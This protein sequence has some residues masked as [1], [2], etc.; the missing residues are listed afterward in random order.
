M[1]IWLVTL[2]DDRLT[3]LSMMWQRGL[4]LWYDRMDEAWDESGW[5]DELTRWRGNTATLLGFESGDCVVPK[6]S[7]GHALRTVLNAF[8]QDRPVKVVATR[9]EF[10]SI[11][12]VLKIYTNLDRVEV[13]WTE[14]SLEEE[15]VPQFRVED[16]IAKL[17]P[18]TDL[19][20]VSAVFF[21]T[22]Q[23]LAGLDQLVEAAHSV[24]AKVLVDV[25]HAA[26]VI[27]LFLQQTGV[28]FAIGGSY[29]Y[30]RG[31]PGACWLAVHPA[32]LSE[33][34]MRSLD[35]GW[36]AKRNKF[37]YERTDEPEF[38]T[39]GDGWMESTPAVLLPYQARAGLQ[40]LLDLGVE[41]V[42][43]HSMQANQMLREVLG[44]AAFNPATPEGWG[45][46]SLV[47]SDRA[48]EL[49]AEL[50]TKGIK[51]DAR[52]NFVRICPD[53]LTTNDDIEQV[54]HALKV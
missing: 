36:F 13:V 24:G 3:K 22:G 34:E 15:G 50:K 21:T 51:V 20:V 29:K 44:S 31:G 25:Y 27:P 32:V 37:S 7:A 28:D 53:L 12:F 17:E 8:P 33:N 46:F 4:N 38:E 49:T 10:D 40:L 18:G 54:A 41:R 26:G 47:R 5:L 30:L 19:V 35:T 39:G 9:G 48:N 14:P 23:I 42:R 1:C 43:T 16:M 11:D 52:G 2:L 45:A 6:S